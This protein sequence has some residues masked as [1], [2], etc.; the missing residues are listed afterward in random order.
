MGVEVEVD[1]SLSVD[2]TVSEKD[3]KTLAT[4]AARAGALSK[5][6]PPGTSLQSFIAS[7]FTNN[8]QDLDSAAATEAFLTSTVC[9]YVLRETVLKDTYVYPRQ[10]NKCRMNLKYKAWVLPRQKMVPSA[11]ASNPTAK[12]VTS[13]KTKNYAVS[14][15][16]TADGYLYLF[17]F[18]ADGRV[19]LLYPNWDN[20]NIK[21]RKS[22]AWTA[23]FPV[24]NPGAECSGTQTLLFIFSTGQILGW[25]SFTKYTDTHDIK[26][27]QECYNMFR[28]WLGDYDPAARVEKFVQIRL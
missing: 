17:R 6:L 26:A 21:F 9:G 25:D 19:A 27:G 13:G 23:S 18:S 7:H 8:A 20:Y 22:T 4:A 14:I 28:N 11:I 5:S 16:P 15:Q 24:S 10:G 12:V 1:T 2:N 3:A